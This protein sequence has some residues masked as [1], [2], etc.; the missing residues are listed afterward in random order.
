MRSEGERNY[1][2]DTP[3]KDL[4]KGA[5]S[6]TARRKRRAEGGCLNTLEKVRNPKKS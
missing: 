2:A 3:D 1:T 5:R 6:D 4:K